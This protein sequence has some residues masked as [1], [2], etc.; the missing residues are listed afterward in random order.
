MFAD[1]LQIINITAFQMDIKILI[2]KRG[3]LMILVYKT[4]VCKIFYRYSKGEL[5]RR[6][7]RIFNR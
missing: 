5:W 4:K 3:P 1:K 2:D 6:Y 7:W